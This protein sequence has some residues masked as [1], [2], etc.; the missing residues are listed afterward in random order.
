MVLFFHN[1]NVDFLI[2]AQTTSVFFSFAVTFVGV[3]IL[4]TWE[5]AVETIFILYPEVFLV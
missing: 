1:F 2:D 4:P 3:I 5:V